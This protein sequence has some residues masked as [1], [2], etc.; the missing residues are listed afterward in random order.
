[1]TGYSTEA[2]MRVGE[3]MQRGMYQHMT[4]P[5]VSPWHV[6][7][8][9][10]EHGWFSDSNGHRYFEDSDGASVGWLKADRIGRDVSVYKLE[11]PVSGRV[12]RIP[13]IDF[14]AR[15]LGTRGLPVLCTYSDGT[16]LTGT[17]EHS[18]AIDSVG[19]TFREPGIVHAGDSGCGIYSIDSVGM[20]VLLGVRWQQSFASSLVPCLDRLRQILGEHAV[21]A[22]APVPASPA[23]VAAEIGDED[24][25]GD[26]DINDLLAFAQRYHRGEV[27]DEERQTVR[28]LVQGGYGAW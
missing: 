17:L 3:T 2:V 12:A 22:D 18:L 25:D 26:V 9:S 10:H 21:M 20:P 5:R 27:S 24:G 16:V 8:A 11:R 23:A 7:G 19:F 1:M 13:T 15:A 6:I 28:R 4:A 14:A